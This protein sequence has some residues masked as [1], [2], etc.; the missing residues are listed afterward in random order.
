MLLIPARIA[1]VGCRQVPMLFKMA[2]THSAMAARFLSMSATRKDTDSAAKCIDNRVVTVGGALS[3]KRYVPKEIYI[4]PKEYD[5]LLTDMDE[6]ELKELGIREKIPNLSAGQFPS[7]IFPVDGVVYG[8][9]GRFMVPLVCQRVRNPKSPIVVWFLVDQGSPHTF[10]SEKTIRALI[11]PEDTLSEGIVAA[12]QD[13]N[14]QIECHT[15]HGH[16]SEVNLLGVNAI[17]DLGL[18]IILI[19]RTKFQLAKM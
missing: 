3:I 1:T 14:S 6:E 8:P 13:P 18:S 9:F 7:L 10:L 4:K 11:D 15:S 12:I 17:L 19:S 2:P 16:F 5:V